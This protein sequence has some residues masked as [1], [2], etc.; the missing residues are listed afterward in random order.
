[1]E[2]GT[3]CEFPMYEYRLRRKLEVYVYC[4]KLQMLEVCQY[5]APGC[6]VRPEGPE[7]LGGQ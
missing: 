5:I 2:S 7:G 6:Y 3:I 4:Y 1:M